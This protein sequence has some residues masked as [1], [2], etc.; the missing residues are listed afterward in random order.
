MPKVFKY[1]IG[2][3]IKKRR[4]KLGLSQ[5]DLSELSNV[6]VN[7]ISRIELSDKK[8]SKSTA[9]ITLKILIQLSE[10]LEISLNELLI[11]NS[12][13]VSSYKV[14]S[15]IVQL[16]E[17]DPDEADEMSQLFLEIL[18]KINKK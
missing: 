8:D 17:L 4:K 11:P 2:E 5:E 1:S 15:L 14:K 3:N 16:N 12:A 13:P 10:A 6:S 7:Y 9:N 18:A